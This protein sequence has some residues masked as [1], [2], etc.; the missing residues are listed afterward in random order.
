MSA[1]GGM[2]KSQYIHAMECY[3]VMNVTYNMIDCENVILESHSR[4][5][6]PCVHLCK[7]NR[8]A[9]RTMFYLPLYSLLMKLHLEAQGFYQLGWPMFCCS[10][11]R[12]QNSSGLK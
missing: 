7:D 8:Q 4:V 2:G 3:V 1:S 6:S 12:A 9:N 5:Y 10:H 11:Q